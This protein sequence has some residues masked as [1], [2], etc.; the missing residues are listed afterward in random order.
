MVEWIKRGERVT[1]VSF[2]RSFMYVDDDFLYEGQPTAGFGFPCNEE[3]EIDTTDEHYEAWRPNFEACLTGTVDGKRVKD[4]GVKRYEN[5]YWEPGILKCVTCGGGVVIDML[6]T[7]TCE[8]CR[9]CG[10]ERDFSWHMMT[11]EQCEVWMRHHTEGERGCSRAS[12]HHEYEP[13]NTDYNSSGQRL[14]PR[15]QWGW[16][17]GETLDEILSADEPLR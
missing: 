16:D 14:A 7:N 9:S 4:F 15:S 1:V 12:E 17:T 5:R 3:G 6:M 10:Q 2:S 13:C 11:A 8:L